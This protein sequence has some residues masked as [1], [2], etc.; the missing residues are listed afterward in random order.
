MVNKTDRFP[1]QD[2]LW[3]SYQLPHHKNKRHN[4][5][6]HQARHGSPY[7]CKWYLLKH[8]V[9]KLSKKIN[10]EYRSLGRTGLRVS[11]ITS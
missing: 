10:M 1:L 8:L 5:K 3:T 11:Q 7:H 9:I 2:R 4:H 6:F